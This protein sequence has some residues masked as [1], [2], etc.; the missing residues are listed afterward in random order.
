MQK[1]LFQ[2]SQERNMFSFNTTFSLSFQLQNVI[3]HT[4]MFVSSCYRRL[5][6]LS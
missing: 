1:K 2:F 5:L 4:A 3:L 6:A